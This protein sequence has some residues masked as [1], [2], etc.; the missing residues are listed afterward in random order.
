VIGAP[1]VDGAEGSVEVSPHSHGMLAEV[2]GTE[3]ASAYT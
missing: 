3:P 2:D 1:G